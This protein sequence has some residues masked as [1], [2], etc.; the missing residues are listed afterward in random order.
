MDLID[1]SVDRLNEAPWNPNIM[2]GEMFERLRESISRYGLVEPL[3][4]RPIGEGIFEVLSGNHRLRLFRETGCDT[5]SCVVVDLDDAHA[6]LLSQALNHV[7][8][9]DDLGLR[10][11]L[12]RHVLEGLPEEEVL[13]LLPETLDSLRDLASLGQEDL[14]AYLRAWQRAQPARLRHL[15]FQ[16]T[17]IQLDVVEDAIE[18]AMSAPLLDEG[19]PNKRGTALTA[20]CRSY[21][22]PTGGTQ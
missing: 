13:S 16:L 15:Q 21:L 3:V 20:I 10:A 18:R 9:D 1:I 8:G 11:E 2:D 4:V 7:H 17:D 5:A 6:R 12:M 14:A 22:P 19:S